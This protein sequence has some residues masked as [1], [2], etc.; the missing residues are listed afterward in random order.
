MGQLTMNDALDLHVASHD[1]LI[2]AHRN[3]FDV[4]SKG[5]PLEEHLQS[6]LDSPKHRLATWYVGCIAG[7]V[8]V[9][10]GGYPLQFHVRGRVVPGVAIGSVYTLTEFRGR[11]IAPRLLAYVE[12]QQ[13]AAGC[14]LSL[15]YS[16]IDPNYYARLGYTL[17]PSLEG[18]R[19]PGDDL[20]RV[21]SQHRLIEISPAEHIPELTRL[22][23]DYHGVLPLAIARNT[24]YWKALL[25]RSPE[26]RFF[27]PGQRRAMAGLH[28]FEPAGQCLASDRLRIG[29]CVD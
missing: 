26:D 3:V 2:A 5:L 16:D 24:G 17:C 19:A 12:Q 10:L 22:Y 8:V 11:G 25:E 6:R 13:Q 9:S 14:V 7:Q 28:P 21:D 1:E 15:L 29:R 4:W 27:A 23:A 18:W 20:G